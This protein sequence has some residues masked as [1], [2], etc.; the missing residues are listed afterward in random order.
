MRILITMRELHSQIDHSHSKVFAGKPYITMAPQWRLLVLSA[1]CQRW[2]HYSKKWKIAFQTIQFLST[3][4]LWQ[5]ERRPET[6]KSHDEERPGRG[7]VVQCNTRQSA[8]RPSWAFFFVLFL[9][10]QR[11]KNK[12]NISSILSKYCLGAS[13]SSPGWIIGR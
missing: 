2:S 13:Q 5:S 6:G 7:G 12:S 8:S 10:C 9:T 4:Q 3:M 1:K 11:D